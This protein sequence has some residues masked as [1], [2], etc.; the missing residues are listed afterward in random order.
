MDLLRSFNHAFAL[1]ILSATA[2]AEVVVAVRV[3]LRYL[4]CAMVT[5]SLAYLFSFTARLFFE[6]GHLNLITSIAASVIWLSLFF[7]VFEMKIVESKLRSE[8][9]QEYQ[10]K[11]AAV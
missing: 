8:S 3:R 4:D 7:F 5:I 2:L 10:D 11:K 9:F 6:G 1:F